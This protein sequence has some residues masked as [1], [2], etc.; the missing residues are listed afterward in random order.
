MDTIAFITLN[1]I[2]A[3][4]SLFMD[5]F[6]KEPWNDKYRSREQVYMFIKS[7]VDNNYF[8]GYLLKRNTKVIALCIGFQKALLE[9][10]EYY[11]DQFCVD[12]TYQGQGIGSRFLSLIEEDIRKRDIRIIELNTNRGYLAEKFYKKNGFKEL[13]DSMILVKV[14]T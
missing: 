14:N 4:A 5:T 3:C 6:S 13:T 8:I 10:N 11:I 2:D 7:Y 12:V 1:D 9:G